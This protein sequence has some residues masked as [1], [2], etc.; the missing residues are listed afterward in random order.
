MPRWLLWQGEVSQSAWYRPWFGCTPLKPVL[1]LSD[2]MRSC[3]CTGSRTGR[4]EVELG[5]LF[6]GV[7]GAEVSATAGWCV[8]LS[9]VP[10][11]VWMHS[12]VASTAPVRP[13]ELLGFG[14][15]GRLFFPQHRLLLSRLRPARCRATRLTRLASRLRS[16]DFGLY[17]RVVYVA[18]TSKKLIRW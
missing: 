2:L 11:M 5:C 10:A 15:A 9:L 16:P 8:A 17:A 4:G 1:L 6:R 13:D 14:H 12:L 7:E 18:S 3:S